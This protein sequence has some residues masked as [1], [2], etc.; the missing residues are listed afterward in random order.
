[1]HA[2]QDHGV[3]GWAHGHCL[4]LVSDPVNLHG[5]LD[6]PVL[7]HIVLGLERLSI[8]VEYQQPPVDVRVPI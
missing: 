2:Q 1:M 5:E 3:C 4:V 7:R 8:A 6:G